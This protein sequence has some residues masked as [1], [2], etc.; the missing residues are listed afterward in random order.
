MA[1]YGV[2]STN[3]T[4]FLQ[5]PATAESHATAGDCERE[6]WP[7][8]EPKKQPQ[9]PITTPANRESSPPKST[10]YPTAAADPMNQNIKDLLGAAARLLQQQLTACAGA[11]LVGVPAALLQT[12]K[13]LLSVLGE[14]DRAAPANGHIWRAHNWLQRMS[15][16]PGNVVRNL[17]GTVPTARVDMGAGCQ[18][19]RT[20]LLQLSDYLTQAVQFEAARE[21]EADQ[22]SAQRSLLVQLPQL[23][24]LLRLL[25]TTAGQTIDALADGRPAGVP[26]DMLSREKVLAQGVL[27]AEQVVAGT[28]T[29]AV[30]IAAGQVL[31]KLA[32]AP[33][34]PARLAAARTGTPTPAQWAAYKAS[35]QSVVQHIQRAETA[36]D[37]PTAADYTIKPAPKGREGWGLQD[38]LDK[39]PEGLRQLR[40]DNPNLF[41]QLYQKKFGIDPEY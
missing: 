5:P 32:A 7:D 10:A 4:A 16:A 35:M 22:Q 20:D 41:R 37:A 23:G 6:Q 33:D 40:E 21:G 25:L 27:S 18:A 19:Y 38:W 17:A 39:D 31:D 36:A 13:A 11:R 15:T 29:A 26:A 30:L 24:P 9:Q 34:N 28:E 2:L 1:S 12:E 3:V 14:A 8:G